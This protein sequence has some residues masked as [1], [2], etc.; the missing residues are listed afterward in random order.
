MLEELYRAAIVSLNPYEALRTRLKLH[1][2]MLHI[3]GAKGL[4]RIRLGAFSKVFAVGM[5]KAAARMAGSL[6]AVLGNRLSG[7]I[8][9]VPEGYKERLDRVELY[10][11]SHPLPDE[12]SLRAAQK[13]RQLAQKADESTLVFFL[14]SGGA[15][16]VLEEG[17]CFRFGDETLQINLGDLRTTIE[18]LLLGGAS[19]EELNTVRKHLSAL[20]GGRLLQLFG[21]STCV[22][23]VLSDVVGDPLD[24]IASGPTI[25][26][27]STYD[28]ALGIVERLG[29]S[30]KL[31]ETV[32]RVL[33]LGAQ[34]GLPE[35]PSPR[36]LSTIRHEAVLIGSN[37][38]GLE[39]AKLKAKN[40]GMRAFT[41]TSRLQGE[42]KEAAKVFW[43]I[44]RD[45]L[46]HGLV[47]R[48]PVVLLAGGETTV[49][50]RGGGKGGR[51]Q[52]FA[53]S[54][55]LEAAKE[56]FFEDAIVGLV[57]ASDGKDG[58]SEAAGAF[59][60]PKLLESQALGVGQVSAYL[61]RNDSASFFGKYGEVFRTGPTGTN[62]C[63]YVFLWI[64][65]RPK[66][67]KT[68]QVKDTH[69]SAK[70]AYP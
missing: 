36:E 57:A 69:G 26:D 2:G 43:A 41:I 54:M 28:D 37:R 20:K 31:P 18:L 13:V 51:C 30:K 42:A 58:N 46:E 8:A 52:E 50:V 67:H 21:R 9:I 5:G 27:Q 29:I 16:S 59:I 49:T 38:H 35:T 53:L 62:A 39:A 11:S 4:K 23:L 22:S 17:G 55:L 70:K 61:K 15:S 60:F 68:T 45:C 3:R 25:G 10:E 47:S 56:G 19:I 33:N 64:R 48:P 32:M 12:R 65:P 40:L 44:A 63:D 24:V 7:G 34:G 14:V 1:E 66:N 6:E